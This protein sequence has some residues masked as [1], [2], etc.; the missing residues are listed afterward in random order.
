M[1]G[2]DEVVWW[3]S[4]YADYSMLQYI[5]ESFTVLKPGGSDIK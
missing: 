3:F 4:D 5:S 2:V 1:F